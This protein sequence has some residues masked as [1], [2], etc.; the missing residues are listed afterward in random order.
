M[1]EVESRWVI[2]K[3]CNECNRL[4]ECNHVGG[5]CYISPRSKSDAIIAKIEG[6]LEFMRIPKYVD[7]R[8]AHGFFGW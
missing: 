5:L 6:R 7:K 4:K 8:K 1:I 2:R 3:V